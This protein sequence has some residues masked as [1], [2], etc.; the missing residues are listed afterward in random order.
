M[1]FVRNDCR[2]GRV[3]LGGILTPHA[4]FTGTASGWFQWP[5]A[6]DS[7]GVCLPGCSTPSAP[8]EARS[9][10]AGPAEATSSG[11]PPPGGLAPRSPA[12]RTPL[13]FSGGYSKH[14]GGGRPGLSNYYSP[15]LLVAGTGGT[16]RGRSRGAGRSSRKRVRGSE[17]REWRWEGARLADRPAVPG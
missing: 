9:R 4:D 12:R 11:I 5:G 7:G 3:R 8:G 14:C 15:P 17:E 10:T 2:D 1:D 13:G 16:G 6:R